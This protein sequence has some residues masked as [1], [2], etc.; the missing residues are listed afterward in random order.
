MTIEP[1]FWREMMIGGFCVGVLLLVNHAI[2]LHYS[3]KY[4]QPVSEP[5][6]IAFRQHLAMTLLFSVQLVWDV[7]LRIILGIALFN[8]MM[9]HFVSYLLRRKQS[10]QFVRNI[11]TMLGCIFNR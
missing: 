4:R 1:P 11:A 10:A 8:V 7:R 2:A 6:R 5:A 3:L 9:W